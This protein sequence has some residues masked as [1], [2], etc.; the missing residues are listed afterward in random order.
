MIDGKTMRALAE[1]IGED[2]VADELRRRIAIER[3]R[4]AAAVAGFGREGPPHPGVGGLDFH[5]QNLFCMAPYLGR[6]AREVRA[7]QAELKTLDASEPVQSPREQAREIYEMLVATPRPGDVRGYLAWWFEAYVAQSTMRLEELGRTIAWFSETSQFGGGFEDARA[8]LADCLEQ[9]Q[10]HEARLSTLGFD[11][12]AF[13]AAAIAGAGGIDDITSAVRSAWRLRSKW[14]EADPSYP[15]LEAAREVLAGC[16]AKLSKVSDAGSRLAVALRKERNQ[17][18]AQVKATERF[19]ADRREA[20]ARS[21]VS[22]AAAADEDAV[23]ELTA[24]A[25][26]CPDAF[27]EDFAAAF[28]VLE[29]SDDQL[30]GVLEVL[31]CEG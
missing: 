16:E 20:A 18:L 29:P 6:Q 5:R 12:A 24:L 30:A 22:R 17:A 7:L 2:R 4:I 28:E 27:P 21:L 15:T 23:K 25:A 8:R 10:K 1:A 11:P 3:G 31:L 19:L 9:K 14:L 26:G 13:A